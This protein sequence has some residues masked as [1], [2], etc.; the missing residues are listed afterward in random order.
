MALSFWFFLVEGYLLPLIFKLITS[1]TLEANL[2]AYSEPS[3]TSKLEVF[4]KIVN[5]FSFLTIFAKSSIV[6]IW[7][8]SEFA[9]EASI[10]L[11]KKLHVS[12][13]TGF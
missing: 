4:A 6:D 5:G 10:D 3:Q 12:C 1:L 8:D 13:V 2:E 7:K 11:R 9:S